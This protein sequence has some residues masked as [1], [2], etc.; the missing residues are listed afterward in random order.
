MAL[1]LGLAAFPSWTSMAVKY[2]V[3]WA[4]DPF[5]RQWPVGVM[6]VTEHAQLRCIQRPPV[7]LLQALAQK[8]G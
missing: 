7:H 4:H 2:G 5:I 3:A 1:R 8:R 6:G